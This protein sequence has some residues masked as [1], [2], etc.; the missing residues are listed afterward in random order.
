[1]V[2]PKRYIMVRFWCKTV[3]P[4]FVRDKIEN[5]NCTRTHIIY[6]IKSGRLN[7]YTG[8]DR[9]LYRENHIIISVKCTAEDV[10][11]YWNRDWNLLDLS[12]LI[13]C[14]FSKNKIMVPVQFWFFDEK[15]EVPVPDNF[16]TK[17]LIFLNTYPECGF[18]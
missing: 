9:K 1:L 10:R 17:S 5:V 2:C 16:G 14:R 15:N 7:R 8:Y 13:R 18:N 6:I 12:V 4:D 3:M 11:L